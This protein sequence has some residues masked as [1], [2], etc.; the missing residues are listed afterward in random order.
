VPKGNAVKMGDS[1]GWS[2]SITRKYPHTIKSNDEVPDAVALYRKVLAAQPNN[3][4]TIVTVGF[5]TNLAGLLKSP[6]DS[7]SKLNGTQLV[8]SKVKRLVSMAGS[9]PFGRGFNN[10][11]DAEASKL[12][13]DQWPT[14]IIF[15]GGEIGKKIK[16]GLPLIE[17]EAIQNSPVKDVY[18]INMA[19][20]KND[21]KGRMSWDQTAV[22]VAVRGADPYYTLVPGKM[23][24]MS[25]G[26]NQWDHLKT[27]HFYLLEKMNSIDVGKEIEAMMHHQ[28]VKAVAGVKSKIRKRALM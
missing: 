10:Q 8:R 6:P 4:V 21:K 5:L 9:F 28:P 23:I 15:S 19:K 1:R 16:T 14:E 3:S 27:G 17:N 12:T 25:D 2:D 22:L 18:R 13:F 7:Y 26:S 20:N 24:S 11:K